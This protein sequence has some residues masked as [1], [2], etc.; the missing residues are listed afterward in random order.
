MNQLKSCSPVHH[1]NPFLVVVC[2]TWGNTPV[3]EEAPDLKSP[4]PKGH[5]GC[6]WA[7]LCGFGQTT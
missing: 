5:C 3:V 2:Q 4:R 1:L 6:C 7:Q